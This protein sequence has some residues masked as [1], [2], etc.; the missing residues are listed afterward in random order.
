MLLRLIFCAAD[1]LYFKFLFVLTFIV[2]SDKLVP[3]TE[4]DSEGVAHRSA[5][6]FYCRLQ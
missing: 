4:G 6:A 3:V 1:I 2:F 5:Y